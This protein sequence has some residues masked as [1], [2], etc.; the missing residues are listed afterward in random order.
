MNETGL[1]LDENVSGRLGEMLRTFGHDVFTTDDLGRKGSTDG[2]QFSFTAHA[3]R[4]F[5]THDAGDFELLHEAW[6]RWSHDWGV[7][8]GAVH[9]GILLLLLPD[10][11]ILP[12]ADRLL[13]LTRR[14]GWREI[15]T[16]RGSSGG[17][18]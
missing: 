4:V 8:E 18:Q 16:E 14:S 2:D 15:E 12:L 6:R 5:V 7:T 10:P 3:G 17:E 9:A 11:G 1:Y 13:A